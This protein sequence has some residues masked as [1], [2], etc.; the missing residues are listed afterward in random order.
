MPCPLLC[1]LYYLQGLFW[2]IAADI[3]LLNTSSDL[4]LHHLNIVGVIHLQLSCVYI[5]SW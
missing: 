3:V 2:Q 5:V 1:F 4:M